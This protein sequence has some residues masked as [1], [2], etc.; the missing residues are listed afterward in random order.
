M[1]ARGHLGRVNLE[2]FMLVIS[3]M[4]IKLSKILLI[5]I[6]FVLFY[7]PQ[8]FAEIYQ[9]I[10]SEGRPQFSDSPN[11]EYSSSGYAYSHKNN[12]PSHVNSSKSPK[13]LEGIAIELKNNRL[14]R[15]QERIKADKAKARKDKKRQKQLAAVKKRKLA[16]KKARNKEDLAFRSRTKRQGLMQMRKALANYEKKQ[17]IR[18]DKCK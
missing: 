10:D 6:S 17:K 11:E 16:C 4:S 2:G 18:R 14:K 8:I 3:S 12:T 9:W 5:T 7:S 15:E 13:A 1:V